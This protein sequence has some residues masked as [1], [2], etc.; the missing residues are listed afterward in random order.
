MKED[1]KKDFDCIENNSDPNRSVGDN[2][3]QNNNNVRQN[4]V[5]VVTYY[6]SDS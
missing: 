5:I 3:W 2:L 1:F 4:N 6:I